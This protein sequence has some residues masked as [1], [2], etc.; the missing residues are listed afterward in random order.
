MGSFRDS[1]RRE[2]QVRIDVNVIRDVRGEQQ[3]NLLD[4]PE[5]GFALLTRLT[6]D[7]V[8]LVDI[9]Y[10]VCRRQARERSISDE[11]F[12]RAMR[13]DCLL[14]AAEVLFREVIDFFPDARRR[15]LLTKV[16]EAGLALGEILMNRAAQQ[17]ARLDELDLEEEATALT[18]SPAAPE[19][20]ASGLG[21][22]AGSSPASSASTPAGSPSPS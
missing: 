22:S 5:S 16:L 6:T 2:W 9:L 10:V 12:G 1:E 18:Q 21:G 14:P 7:L 4:L 11:D 19:A 17:T 20:S 3:I 8:L 15:A 13:G